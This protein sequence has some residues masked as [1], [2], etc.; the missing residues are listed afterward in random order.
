[1]EKDVIKNDGSDNIQQQLS[2]LFDQT[3]NNLHLQI[4]Q[5]SELPKE[6]RSLFQERAKTLVD[7]SNMF[8]FDVLLKN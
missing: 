5:I 4:R 2:H 3:L 6:N 1:M 8:I 7:L